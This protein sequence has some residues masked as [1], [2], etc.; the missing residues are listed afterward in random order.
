MYKKIKK[1]F[2]WILII[3]MIILAFVFPYSV[4]IEDA[5]TLEA[6]NEFGIKISIW[7][8]IFEPILGVLLF[9]NRSLYALEEL[10]ILLYW[11][12]GFYFV[13]TLFKY[14]FA[15]H[16]LNKKSYLVNQITNLPLVV[17][18]WFSFFV[19]IIF[20]PLPN[21]TILNN[22]PDAVLVTTHSHSEYSHDGLTSQM[23]LWEW[24]KKNNFDAFFITDHGNHVKT[25]EF[26]KE[27][28][29]NKFDQYPF[30]M[31]GQEFSG[32]NHMSLL[33]LKNKFE[34]KGMNDSTVV[35]ATH[36]YNGVVLINHWFSKQ[37]NELSYHKKL[38]IDGY[39]IENVGKEL[40]YDRA[41]YQ[42]IKNF[43][44]ANNLIMVG[45]LD[46]HGYGRSASVWNAF[47][48]PNW[49]KLNTIDKEEA[50]IEIIRNR[51]QDKL[52][53]L[54]YKDRPYY[55]QDNLWFS[56]IRFVRDYFR[57]LN[58]YQ[59]FSWVLWLLFIGFFLKKIKINYNKFIVITGVIGS[60]FL[61]LLGIK[62]H[63]RTTVVKGYS[64]VYEEYSTM[65]FYIGTI[66]IAY[67]LVLLY[68][69]FF[70]Q[71]KQVKE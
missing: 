30:I 15:K 69:R 35:K 18:I 64:E 67:S 11:T 48:I 10:V 45:G 52:Q 28:Q 42:K 56:P 22:S 31:T 46:F 2:I 66:F 61:I 38:K 63:I 49:K 37:R 50:I 24:H 27:Q 17:G 71:K 40:Y 70:A 57:T 41:L 68:F 62:Y 9:L 25:F 12:I 3:V 19:V 23:G 8:I 33:G 14:F 47:K 39:E 26:A 43:S 5:L 4:R 51:E 58:I 55:T 29:A 65:L 20:I 6:V 59:V 60:V 44:T 13:N 7:R 34:T 21:N 53:V 1:Y 36:Y 16:S 54:M 32:T